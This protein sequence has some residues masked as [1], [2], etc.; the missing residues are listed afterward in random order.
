MDALDIKIL[1]EIGLRLDFGPFPSSVSSLRR[2]ASSLAVD[3]ETV[4]TRLLSL[5]QRGILNGWHAMVNPNVLSMKVFR[6]WA[7]FT[8][9]AAKEA[10]V[11][12][13]A[14]LPNVRVV[15]NYSGN[16]LSFV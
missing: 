6:V 7:E 4:R 1:S 2:I 16:S 14:S 8:S 9:E 10:E 11:K 12:R 5:H 3:K 13:L 15:Y